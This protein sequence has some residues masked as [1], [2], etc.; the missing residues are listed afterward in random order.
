M[1]LGFHKKQ[2]DQ[3]IFL[4][5]TIDNCQKV[6]S[7]KSMTIFFSNFKKFYT[8]HKFFDGNIII[9]D[10]FKSF[11]KCMRNVETILL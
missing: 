9:F 2:F 5:K 10:I 6:K 4:L 1:I 8:A 3:R 11:I 7:T